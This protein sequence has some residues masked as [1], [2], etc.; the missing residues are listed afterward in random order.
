MAARWRLGCH[1]GWRFGGF[2]LGFA[3]RAGDAGDV[4]GEFVVWGLGATDRETSFGFV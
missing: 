4:E 3:L 2:R 1:F